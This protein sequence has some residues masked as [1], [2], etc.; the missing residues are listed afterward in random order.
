MRGRATRGRAVVIVLVG[1]VAVLLGVARE[2]AEG[3]CPFRGACA[4]RLPTPITVASGRVGYRIA[5][6]GRARRVAVASS[7]YP[8]GASWF[9]GTDTWF[10]IRRRHLVVGRGQ[11]TLWRS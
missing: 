5:R 8:R 6:D 7:P 2:D 11:Q 10:E 1:L 3:A 9:P 4:L